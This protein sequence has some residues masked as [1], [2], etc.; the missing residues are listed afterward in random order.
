M[1][2]YVV[3]FDSG[4]SNSRI[5]LLDKDFQVLYVAK[6][7]VGSRNSSI[8]G[9]NKVLIEGLYELYTTLLAEKNLKEEDIE[10][11]Y[12]SGMIT[13]PYGMKEVP[14][15][16][17]PLTVQGF[18]DSLYCHYEDTCFKRNIYLVPGLKTVSEDFSYV[19]NMRGEEIEILG[20]LEELKE[21]GITNA[22]LMMPGSHTHVTYVKDD[23]ITD[24][25]S[26]FT[27]E[28]FYAIKK[29]TI[30]APVLDMNV[31]DLDKEM[32]HK[33]IDNLKKFG[34]NRALYICH[35]MRIMNSGTPE[36]RF[37][38]GEGV[39]MGSL[40]IGL[41]HYCAERWQGCDTLV[42]VSDEF[43]YK[44]FSIIFE[45]SEYI[46]KIV[47]LPITATKSYAV[48]GLKKIISLME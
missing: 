12:I 6:K 3:Y 31:E 38:Y 32:I 47:W 42:I 7:N 25:L 27:G 1:A 35:A 16:V 4:T 30:L 36:Q 8:E 46:K 40:R 17:L 20:T 14:H 26:N 37:A 2:D 45:G 34:F 41:E 15:L 11:I 10:N 33:A 39:V 23:V 48:E 5:Y 13:S 22:A 21:M 18:A 28:L 29:E 24:I 43:M 44:L 19:G 9:S